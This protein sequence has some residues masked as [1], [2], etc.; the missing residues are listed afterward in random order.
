MD[1]EAGI[2]NADEKQPFLDRQ[3]KEFNSRMIT[4]IE[5]P[6]AYFGK[7]DVPN[8]KKNSGN[9]YGRKNSF[10]PF[11]ILHPV[12]ETVQKRNDERRNI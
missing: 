10:P 9:Y 1:E 2:R 12:F 5:T 3:I 8:D 6:D 4:W 11:D 7:N